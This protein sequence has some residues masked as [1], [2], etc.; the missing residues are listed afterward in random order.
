MKLEGKVAI[1]TGASRG[2]GWEI[3]LGFADEGADLA[4]CARDGT[5]LE[6]LVGEI[7]RRGRRALAVTAD[8]TLEADVTRLAERT[9]ETFGRIDV[10]CNNAGVF[11][12]GAVDALDSSRWDEVIAVNLRGPFLCSRAVLPH[13]KRQNYGRIVDMSSGSAI[14][15]RPGWG[16]YSASKAALNALSRTLANE[17][18]GFNILVN[19]M[20]PGFLKTDMNPQGTRLPGAA[21]P[22]AVE[23]ASLPDGGPSGRFFRFQQELEVI[24]DLSKLDWNK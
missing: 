20:S 21:V 19:A 24:P 9:V 6:R 22:T 14:N 23:L 3:A 8:V 16:A 5:R 7:E 4:V 12:K 11:H 10:L 13:M 18:T 15:C 1:V 17:L 2:I